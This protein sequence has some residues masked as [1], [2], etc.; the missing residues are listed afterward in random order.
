MARRGDG[1]V[2]GRAKGVSRGAIA[3]VAPAPSVAAFAKDPVGR[4]V[5]GASFVYCWPRPD[6]CAT[7]LFGAPSA[8]DLE[9]LA[10]LFALELRP[11]AEPHASL[12]DARRIERVEPRAFEVLTAYVEEQRG[13]MQR[14]VTRLA[15]VR[16]DG[17]VGALAAGFYETTEPPYP[18]QIFAD[19]AS[20]LAWLGRDP[21]IEAAWADAVE[22]MAG[23][24]ELLGELARALDARL[25][26]ASIERAAQDLGTSVRTLQRRLREHDTT[27]RER[28][29]LAQVAAA[30]RWLRQT[31][32]PVS[33]IAYEVGCGTPQQLSRLFRRVTG[34]TPTAWRAST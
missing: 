33:R 20:A 28:L 18:V 26:E 22:R 4:W 17:F 21:A 29:A 27:F 3:P 7:V 23:A 11:P 16:P 5:G 13:A 30:K 2:P 32:A 9:A 25:P 24:P 14:W 19:A 1:D 6:L 10:R 34:Q 15:I 8:D 12:I 31:D